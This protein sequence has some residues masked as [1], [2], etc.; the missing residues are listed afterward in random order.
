A[1]AQAQKRSIPKKQQ[2]WAELKAKDPRDYQLRKFRS[3]YLE[4]VKQR[5]LAQQVEALNR[6][7]GNVRTSVA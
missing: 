3:D 5:L 7:E 1:I 2:A 6:F 4:M